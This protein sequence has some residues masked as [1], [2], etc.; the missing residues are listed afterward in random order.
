MLSVI[1]Y[2]LGDWSAAAG[3]SPF[4]NFPSNLTVLPNSTRLL[5]SSGT[6]ITTAYVAYKN[7]A[8]S[9]RTVIGN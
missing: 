3:A 5:V 9:I 7:Q 1:E 6:D 4:S 8:G 2:F